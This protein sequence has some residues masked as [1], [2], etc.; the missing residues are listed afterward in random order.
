MD[1]I[2]TK[3]T[4]PKF[5][6]VHRDSA[7]ADG[8]YAAGDP[9]GSQH[10]KSTSSIETVY[11]SLKAMTGESD[12]VAIVLRFQ[13]QREHAKELDADETNTKSEVR[14]CKLRKR[15]LQ[16]KLSRLQ[17]SGGVKRVELDKKIAEIEANIDR[18]KENR[19]EDEKQIQNFAEIMDELLKKL[20]S[21][22]ANNEHRVPNQSPI[23][24]SAA[25]TVGHKIVS[26][27]NSLVTAMEQIMFENEKVF[28]SPMLSPVEK[29][30][31]F[32][33]ESPM[34]SLLGPSFRYGS[35]TGLNIHEDTGRASALDVHNPDM[36]RLSIAPKGS[37][38]PSVTGDRDSGKR[39]S[40]ERKTDSS[41]EEEAAARNVIKRQS[42]VLVDAKTRKGR[43][44]PAVAI[45]PMK[46]K[47]N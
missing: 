3:L 22:C 10:S 20:L 43:F 30:L 26:I 18:V 1:A 45:M 29:E 33:N 35:M 5:H 4:Y 41:E 44:N 32:D 36:D 11:I 19:N 39:K 15:F 17:Y 40:A 12:P 38:S 8:S 42:Q 47:R 23:L 13:Q 7:L 25:Q 21:I 16:D 28:M 2:G 27:L 24:G 9:S 31:L 6:M 37:A 34:S 46:G 14:K